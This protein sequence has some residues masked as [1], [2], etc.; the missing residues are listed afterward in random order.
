MAKKTKKRDIS[1]VLVEAVV[2]GM[3]A[4]KGQEIVS[5]N[6]AKINS[7]VCDFFVICHGNS[8]THTAALAES[9]EAVVRKQY[10]I[11]PC[12]R[13]GYVN[14]EWLLLDYL[15]VVVHIFQ[16]PVRRYYQL[17]ELWADVPLEKI[18]E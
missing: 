7:T 14:G 12:R 8:R 10:G 3:L 4:K 6:L 16:E 17:E 18:E 11:K 2:Q 15:D 1:E 9:V 5:L 13:E